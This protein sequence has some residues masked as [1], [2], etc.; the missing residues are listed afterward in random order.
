M[1]KKTLLDRLNSMEEQLHPNK[2]KAGSK[3]R[4]FNNSNEL[5]ALYGPKPGDKCTVNGCEA[6]YLG[7]EIGP[8]THQLLH[9][10]GFRKGTMGWP[11][12]YIKNKQVRDY[13]LS[14]GITSCAFAIN[15][16]II[17]NK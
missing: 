8:V 7:K 17:W 6:I 10:H 14:Q 1:E 5:E 13:A 12:E 4:I 9:L 15:A 11:A 16:T 2:I 3:L